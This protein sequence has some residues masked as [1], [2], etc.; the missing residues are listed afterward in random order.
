MSNGPS[1]RQNPSVLAEP[2]SDRRPV[3]APLGSW[4]LAIAV[5]GGVAVGAL[6]L[7]GQ[8]LLPGASNQLANSGAVWSA[9][10]F[11]A[12][13]LLPVRTRGAAVVGGLTLIGAVVGYYA[14][15]TVFLHDDVD[16]ATMRAPLLWIVIALVAGPVSGFAGLL[17]RTDGRIWIRAVAADLIGAVFI[18][19]AVYQA[20]VNHG[21]AV[22]VM[23]AVIGI[24]LPLVFAR[25]RSDRLHAV[26]A[27]VP[28][29]IVGVGAVGAVYA[30]VNAVL[31]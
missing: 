9:A 27:F 10:A 20:A 23:L 15:T 25:S 16:A 22:A 21:G 26:I 17:V 3:D 1:G 14:S 2:M 28:V 8:R 5:L 29:S 31:G 4:S 13:R 6:T 7:A 19:E 24:L 11:A 18:G 30:V 12:G